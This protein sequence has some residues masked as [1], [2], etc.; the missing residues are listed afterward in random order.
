MP[1]PLHGSGVTSD[2]TTAL[3]DREAFSGAKAE[4]ADVAS[5]ADARPLPSRSECLRRVFDYGD[6]ARN[7]RGN[8]PYP[9]GTTV[10]VR[11]LHAFQCRDGKICREHGYEIWRDIN[12]HARVND[13]VPAGA[14]V[15]TFD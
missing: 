9:P 6:V 15:E 3:V 8:C 5:Q 2:Q 13:D 14:T 1:Q 7:R 4:H 12:D 11:L 10:S